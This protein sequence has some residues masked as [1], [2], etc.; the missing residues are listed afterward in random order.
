[1]CFIC[2]ETE[3]FGP[4][5]LACIIYLTRTNLKLNSSADKIK[6]L[7]HKFIHKID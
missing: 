1:M 4:D 3:R 2:Q 6:I 7:F 5:Y